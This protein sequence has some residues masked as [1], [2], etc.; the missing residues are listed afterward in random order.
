[1]ALVDFPLKRSN[2][3]IH[4]CNAKDYIALLQHLITLHSEKSIVIV[5]SKN[6]DLIKESIDL[7]SVTFLNDGALTEQ[8][9][10]FD[11]LI[12][13]DI[14]KAV[15]DYMARIALTESD[16]VILIDV[17]KMHLLY[18]L[19]TYLKRAI[20]QE[21]IV[22]FEPISIEPEVKETFTPRRGERRELYDKKPYDKNRSEGKPDDKKPWDKKRSEGKPGDKKPWD[23]KRSEAKPGDKKPWDKKP[24]ANESAKPARAS[25]KF[26]VKADKLQKKDD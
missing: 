3:K 8:K 16:A 9:S 24:R 25:K 4:P 26:I 19:E 23:K 11:L 5:A 14:P 21:V 7:G 6:I 20:L 15:E 2:H 18:P 12:S 10:K 1:M 17:K 22:G 13:L